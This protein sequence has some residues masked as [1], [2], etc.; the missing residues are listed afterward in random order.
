VLETTVEEA[1]KKVSAN[2]HPLTWKVF[3]GT[4]TEEERT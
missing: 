4:A 1:K 3:T 2:I